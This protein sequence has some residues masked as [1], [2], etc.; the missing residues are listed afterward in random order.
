[1]SLTSCGDYFLY[2]MI[3]LEGRVGLTFPIVSNWKALPPPVSLGSS[4]FF[5]NFFQSIGQWGEKS[6]WLLTFKK[7]NK[8]KRVTNNLELFPFV[9]QI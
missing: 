9:I 7:V 2:I 4:R 5:F 1:M 3:G 6:V 8:L